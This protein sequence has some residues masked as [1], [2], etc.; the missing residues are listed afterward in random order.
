MRQRPSPNSVLLSCRGGIFETLPFDRAGVANGFG[1]F[2]GGFA[3][4]F[5]R[6]VF[7]EEHVG[8][9]GA[10]NSAGGFDGE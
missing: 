2:D 10:V 1:G 9:F 7:G 8:Q 5:V 6:N 4:G 3:D